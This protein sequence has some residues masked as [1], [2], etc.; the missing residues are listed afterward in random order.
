MT[1]PRDRG[2][3]F[4]SADYFQANSG[5]YPVKK[6]IA[7]TAMMLLPGVAIAQDTGPAPQTGME[8]PAITKGAKENGAMDTTTGANNPKGHMKKDGSQNHKS[9]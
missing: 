6:F 3:E 9:R 2:T 7:V 8:K 1:V 5:R 4:S